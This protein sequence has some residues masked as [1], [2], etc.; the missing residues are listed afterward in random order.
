MKGGLVSL[1]DKLFYEEKHRPQQ[2]ITHASPIK[3]A[4]AHPCAWRLLLA[5]GES[6]WQG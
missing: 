2:E 1:G 4:T 6:A 3:A 5:S